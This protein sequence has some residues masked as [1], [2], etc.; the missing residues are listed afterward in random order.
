MLYKGDKM[1]SFYTFKNKH[2]KG[3]KLLE[4]VL[5]DRILSLLGHLKLLII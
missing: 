1:S 2:F 3:L 5:Q 4:I